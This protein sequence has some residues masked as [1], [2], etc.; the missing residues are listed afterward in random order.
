MCFQL[1]I[2]GNVSSCDLLTPDNV[3]ASVCEDQ[4]TR[5]PALAMS[6]GSLDFSDDGQLMLT[7]NGKRLSNG[8]Y[9]CNIFLTD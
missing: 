7:Y 5:K 3:K 1:N 9:Y 2:C 8:W 4:T 6:T